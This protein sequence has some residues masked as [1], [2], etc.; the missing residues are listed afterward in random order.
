MVTVAVSAATFFACWLLVRAFGR[1]R[2]DHRWYCG[3]THR[4]NVV[5][6]PTAEYVVDSRVI[7]ESFEYAKDLEIEAKRIRTY[8]RHPRE[9]RRVDDRRK[10]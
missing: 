8:P 4:A 10:S 5:C 1:R 6:Q 3:A 9:F 7:D 2:I